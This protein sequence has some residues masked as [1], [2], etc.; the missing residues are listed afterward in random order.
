[1]EGAANGSKYL[2]SVALG[3][4]RPC[5][6]GCYL[7]GGSGANSVHDIIASLLVSSILDNGTFF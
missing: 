1:M 2:L 3:E 5:Q 7:P 6:I 4:E